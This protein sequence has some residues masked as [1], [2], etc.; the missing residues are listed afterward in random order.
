MGT[1]QRTSISPRKIRTSVCLSIQSYEE[2]ERIASAKKVSLAWM[3]R[4]AVE[5]YLNAKRPLFRLEDP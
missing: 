2:L 5:Q 1:Q 4:E 3:V